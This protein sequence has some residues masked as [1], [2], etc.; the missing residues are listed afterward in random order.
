M[1][2]G[3]R[4]I[5][6][7]SSVRGKRHRM[8]VAEGSLFVVIYGPESALKRPHIAVGNM[9]VFISLNVKSHIV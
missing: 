1:Q 9:M 5:H 4:T 6:V 2:N 3:R 7:H 8:A